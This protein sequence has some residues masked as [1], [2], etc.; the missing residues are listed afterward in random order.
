MSLSLIEQIL[1]YIE[2][3]KLYSYEDQKIIHNFL[4]NDCDEKTKR[5]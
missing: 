4:M 1:V 2:N 3:E 5:I